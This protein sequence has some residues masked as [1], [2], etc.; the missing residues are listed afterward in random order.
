MRK[1][2]ANVQRKILKDS[3]NTWRTTGKGH[4]KNYKSDCLEGIYKE[5]RGGSRIHDSEDPRVSSH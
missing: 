4:F 3:Q 2:E 1:K 5:M